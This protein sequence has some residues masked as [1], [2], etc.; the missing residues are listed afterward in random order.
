MMDPYNLA[1]CFGPTLLPIPESRDQVFYH[2]HV[3]ELMKNM[4]VLHREIFPKTAY[5]GTPLYEKY[6][7]PT[8]GRE[9]ENNGNTSSARSVRNSLRLP[10]GTKIDETVAEV[11]SSDSKVA[12]VATTNDEMEEDDEE[13]EELVVGQTE[14]DD[15]EGNEEDDEA[16]EEDDEEDED[17]LLNSYATTTDVPG[18]DNEGKIL[19]LNFQ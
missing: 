4:I 16:G 17:I 15:D 12:S 1:I 18:E 11:T 19:S 13:E 10:G 3:N 7:L 2:N 6:L 9:E 8:V 14:E 5:P